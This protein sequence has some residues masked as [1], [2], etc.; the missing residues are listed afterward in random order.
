M[1]KIACKFCYNLFKKQY[2]SQ[3]FCSLVCSNRFNLNNKKYAVLPK[4]YSA[5]LAE[6][7]GIMLGDGSLTKYYLK[8]YLNRIND[9]NYVPFV[10]KLVQSLF[11][12]KFISSI[13]CPRRGTNEIQISS[14]DIT[15]Y[16]QRIGFNPKTRKIPDWIRSNKN[17][18]IATLRGLFDT[19]GTVGFKYFRG[20]RGN[21]FYKQLTVTN[22]NDNILTFVEEKL[23]ELGFGNIKRSN[24][25][26]YISNK[27][28]IAMY[29]KMIGSS[30]P[31]LTKKLEIQKIDE[32]TYTEGWQRGRMRCT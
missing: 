1:L 22:T 29:A 30:N 16:I 25:N 9:K 28:D 15:S 18:S 2:G 11:P 10:V 26:I 4:K 6:F 13:D 8:V 14:T 23:C 12:E 7:F 27:T 32:F 24:H 17:Y 19:E 31:K 3:K 20:K 5:D 21:Y